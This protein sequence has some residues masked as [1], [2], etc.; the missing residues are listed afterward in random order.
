MK[1][2]SKN[3]KIKAAAWK[4]SDGVI[5]EGKCHA[6]IIR[7]SPYGTC[8]A[9]SSPGFITTHGRFIDSHEALEIAIKNKQA[10]PNK[11][12]F[13]GCGLLSENIWADNNFKYDPEKG[14]YK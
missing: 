2:K 11:S 7:S 5:A 8:K 9:G 4:R 1:N 14:Y 10:D 13:R 12:D 3:E 6:D